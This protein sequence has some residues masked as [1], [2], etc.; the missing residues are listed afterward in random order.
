MGLY[1]P[2]FLF[3][4]KGEKITIETDYNYK[5][6]KIAG[7]L[8]LLNKPKNYYEQTE[9]FWLRAAFYSLKRE[10]ITIETETFWVT[11]IIQLKLNECPGYL[12]IELKRPKKLL[13]STFSHEK[14]T[15]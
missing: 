4:K 9:T 14:G 7:F 13:A 5:T 12:F 11:T 2:H 6:I 8:Y 1:E 15:K 3:I 10:K